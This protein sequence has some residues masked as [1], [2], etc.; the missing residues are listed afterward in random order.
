MNSEIRIPRSIYENTLEDLRRPHPYAFERV[1][2]LVAKHSNAAGHTQIFL[3][4][5][6]L[7]L[8]DERYIEDDSVGARIDGEAIRSAMQRILTDRVTLLHVHLHDHYGLPTMSS[9][10]RRET[11]PIIQSF[12]NVG[13]LAHGL[14]VFSRNAAIAQIK[15]S[16]TDNLSAVARI[17]V[18]G[19]PLRVLTQ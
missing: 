12:C 9:T 14:L 19:Y 7:P 8:A 18:V 17:S 11:P 3:V 16:K 13:N 1:G 2:F 6:Y 5:D 10:D 4:A 15:A